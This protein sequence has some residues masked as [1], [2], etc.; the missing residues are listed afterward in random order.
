MVLTCFPA[1]LRA[2]ELG[3]GRRKGGLGTWLRRLE[4]KGSL[5]METSLIG[6]VSLRMVSK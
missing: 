5:G 4:G 3:E 1:S 6:V 2:A